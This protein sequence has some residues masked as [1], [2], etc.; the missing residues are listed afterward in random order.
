MIYLN[1]A[2]TTWPKPACVLEA[3][4]Q[5]MQAS[6]TDWSCQFDAAHTALANFVGADKD[7][8]LLTPGCTS[9]LAVAI[10]DFTLKPGD[11]IVTSCFEHHAMHRPLLKWVEQGVELDVIPPSIDTPFR[12][13][14][15]EQSLA[16]GNVKLV[17]VTA[18]SNVTG[19]L[20]PIEKIAKL[21][22]AHGAL[23]LL[24]AAQWVGWTDNLCFSDSAFDIVA[25][26]GHKGLHAPWGIG[27][28]YVARDVSLNTPQA[29]CTIGTDQQAC[30]S[31]PGYCDAG[32]VDRIALA[33]LRAAIEWLQK[34]PDRLESCRNF[35]ARLRAALADK[36]GVVF[37]GSDQPEYRLPTLAFNVAN[38]PSDDIA[39][40][41]SALGLHVASG[42]QCAPLT[43]QIL[44]T[45]DQGTV[46]ISVGP[47]NTEHEI[48]RA[49]EIL[50]AWKVPVLEQLS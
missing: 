20:L 39:R 47:T 44:G 49:I 38:H 21:A 46:R 7:R 48:E 30:A 43:H 27:G 5:A 14:R 25:F 26:G 31:M 1:Q 11:R 41:L 13:D 32:S 24:D 9:S 23:V 19:D 8:L 18:A 2:G 35:V 16:A 34:F 29:T 50:G 4:Q 37:L 40:Q 3:C 33:G 10:Q 45:E 17:A 22:H 15:F 28:L 42:L 6:C 36:P 12:F